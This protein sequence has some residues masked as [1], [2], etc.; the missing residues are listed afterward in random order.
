MRVLYSETLALLYPTKMVMKT[1]SLYTSHLPSDSI[2]LLRVSS[3][4]ETCSSELKEFPLTR[5]P[6]FVAI[7]WCW[8]SRSNLL[9]LSFSCNGQEVPVPSHLHALLC[10][11]T[12]KGIPASTTIWIDAICINQNE[13][14]EKEVHIPRMR[15]IYGK[16]HGMVVWLGKEADGSEL[17]M[18]AETAREMTGKLIK[19]PG[20]GPL[21]GMIKYDLPGPGEPI[22]RAIGR[23]CDR[24]WFY[25]TW[26][27]QEVALAGNIELLC[28]FQRMPWDEL[29]RLVS[30]LVRTELSALCRNS[31]GAPSNRP[32]GFR[33]LL[34]LAFTRT[35]HQDGGCPTDYILRMI[36]LKEV[37][38]PVDKV[39]GLLGLLNEGLKDAISIDYG[40]Y[41][42]RYWKIYLDV[43]K[44]IVAGNQNFWL[45]NMASS[46]ERP[47]ELPSWC[48]NLNSTIPEILD[49][50]SQKWQAGIMP[51]KLSGSSIS[52][53]PDSPCIRISGFVIDEVKAVV[54][55]GGPAPPPD[56]Q[57]GPSADTVKASFL[58]SNTTC[59]MLCQ[60]HYDDAHERINTY[61]RTL[62]VNTW[63][64]GSPILPS[65]RDKASTAYLDSIAY[66][67]GEV[68]TATRTDA[69]NTNDREQV[70]HQ[71]LRQLS[72][73]ANRS[74]YS[75]MHGRIGRGAAHMRAGDIICVF[76]G[77]GPVFVLRRKDDDDVYEL[78]G[79]AY[80]HGCM[81][82]ESLP[83][84][85][86]DQD[87]E[88]VLG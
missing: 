80:L 68:E 64:D 61:S 41:E 81:D 85:L 7:S 40:K 53:I 84:G 39:Y 32:N 30:E 28:G 19:V 14:K 83:P 29:V 50:S 88:F 31:T 4:G 35:M 76:H 60:E 45:L 72:W 33:V 63:A 77:A 86:R 62:I 71:Y 79:D 21:D 24:D 22:W 11:L 46:K 3:N 18:D 2:R 13:T 56:E 55:L 73:W 66:L 67:A 59:L 38:K 52:T 48:P 6:Y 23:L 47:K 74:F 20:Y 54:H 9:Y 43:A 82:L 16:S 34:D 87:Q 36:R 42:Q 78:V 17:V 26:I 5:L 25:R 57:G 65:Q 10:S 8:T 37:T 15:E 12:P 69:L 49:F 70:M 58:E 75:T 44:H 51:G 1:P 27:V